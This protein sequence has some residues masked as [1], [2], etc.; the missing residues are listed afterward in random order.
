VLASIVIPCYNYG[1]FLMDAIGSA[2][3]QTV[4][5]REIIV[6]DDG[7]T[8]AATLAL[9][10]RLQT[11]PDLRVI[12]QANAGLPAARNAGIAAA[13]GEFVCCL[14]AD[15]MLDPTYLECAVARLLTDRAAGFAYPFVRFFGD[16]E[17][18]WET[19]EFDMEEA[20]VANFTAV[21]AVFRRDDWQVAGGYSPV[22]RGGFED[23]EF[24]IRLASL[25]RRG[26]VLRHPLLLHRR[27]GRTMTH[28]AKDQAEELRARIRALNPG[29]FG[30]AALR[31]RLRRLVP[32]R[33]DPATALAPL[34]GAIGPDPRPGLLVVIAW[35]RR[36]G[37][38]VLLLSLLRA[39]APRWR[40]LL[41]TTEA[42]P[43]AMAEE[44]RAVTPEIFHL[45]GTLDPEDRPGFLEHLCQSRGV[46]H[47]L[48]SGS[49][50]LLRVLPGL[51][52]AVPGVAWAHITHNEVADGVFRAALAAGDAVERHVAV[53][54]RVR[55]GLL[56][57]GV[58][59][60]RVVHIE[61]GIDPAPF[62]AALAAREETRGGL[63]VAPGERL[64]L[65][66]GRFAPEKRPGL[67]VSALRDLGDTSIRGAM[68][69]EGPLEGE[70]DAAIAAAGLGPRM[71]RLGHRGREEVARLLGAADLLVLT[72][73]VEGLPLIVLEAQAAGCPV[74]ATDVGDIR[75]VVR[76]GATGALVDP[77]R[78]QELAPA[79][80]S[81]LET[82]GTEAAR[83]RIREDFAATPHTLGAMSGTY[84]ALLEGMRAP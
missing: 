59:P 63:G 50:W 20:L 68:V 48:S 72:S 34:T 54:R 2:R 15:D 6:V 31:R 10:D 65:W 64:L 84:A 8:D 38:E 61:N 57:A 44:F 23:W 67:F 81:A 25:G 3:A 69:G 14:D 29:A 76:P 75:S 17:E 83:R 19:R 36:G 32:A 46:T 56:Q 33:H 78:S 16:V 82:L 24:W 35:A 66:V 42:D 55:Q 9:L 13:T 39:L 30:D 62:A 51:R 53:S 47:G 60:S 26:R 5:A 12:R 7:S 27:H 77:G 43:H 79:I 22:M 52:R 80:R 73:A 49:A 74:V 28:E 40:I 41:V 11:E 71:Q 70:V 1:R 37:A 45:E 4:A 18:V 58:A 21:S